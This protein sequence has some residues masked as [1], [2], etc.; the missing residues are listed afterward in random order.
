LNAKNLKTALILANTMSSFVVEDYGTAVLEDLT[1][2]EVINRAS[3]YLSQLPS[4]YD[5][6]AE[7]MEK[8]Q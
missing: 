6:R 7:G 4:L 5:L 3:M 8:K 2:T 1:L